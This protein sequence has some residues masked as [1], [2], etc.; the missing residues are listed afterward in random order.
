MAAARAVYT[1][2]FVLYCRAPQGDWARQGEWAETDEFEALSAAHA[3]DDEAKWQAVRLMNV[4]TYP[5]GRAP[6]ETI[7]WMTG[8]PKAGKVKSRGGGS[9][10]GD[11]GGGRDSGGGDTQVIAGRDG[12][13]GKRKK[14]KRPTVNYHLQRIF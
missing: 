7:A 6:Q 2:T 14:K 8:I 12:P 11:D 13:P 4:R 1:T 5:D 10:V 9:V 3:A